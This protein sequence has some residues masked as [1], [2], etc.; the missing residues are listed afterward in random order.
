MRNIAN[1]LLGM[2]QLDQLCKEANQ[3]KKK[4]SA[5]WNTGWAN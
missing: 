5:L 2:Q 3:P 4:N 1:F